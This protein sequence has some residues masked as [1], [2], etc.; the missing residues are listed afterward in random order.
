MNV[1]LKDEHAKLNSFFTDRI[2]FYLREGRDQSYDVVK[3]VMAA[4]TDDL[5]DL[6]ARAEAVTAV[7]G[8]EDF[9]AVSAAFKRIKNILAQADPTEIQTMSGAPIGGF[10]HPAEEELW[11]MGGEVRGNAK[12]F[13]EQRKYIEALQAY[14]KMRPAVD[15]FFKQVMIFDPDPAARKARLALLSWI[16][17]SFSVIADFSEIV[18]PTPTGISFAQTS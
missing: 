18:T 9:L 14:G 10:G 8:S 17:K 16:E 11:G 6:V 4:G 5:R 3:A 2:D 12:I 7:R 15:A 13:I 1:S